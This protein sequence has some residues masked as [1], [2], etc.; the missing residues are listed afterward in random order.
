MLIL[1][2]VVEEIILFLFYEG[3]CVDYVIKVFKYWL[4]RTLKHN[5]WNISKNKNG[6]KDYG[7]SFFTALDY[8]MLKF[9]IIEMFF[10]SWS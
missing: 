4:Q 10:T 9:K 3:I 8:H 1:P 7:H 2:A 5:F 6:I